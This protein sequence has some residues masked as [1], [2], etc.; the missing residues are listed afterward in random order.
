MEKG[1]PLNRITN[2]TVT[3]SHGR[4]GAQ[5]WLDANPG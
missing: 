3:L 5:F 4:A 2:V 1:L